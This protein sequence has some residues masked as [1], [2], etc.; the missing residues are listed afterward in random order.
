[1][2]IF[3]SIYSPDKDLCPK[4]S[5]FA[6]NVFSILKLGERSTFYPDLLTILNRQQS[7]KITLS[8]RADIFLASDLVESSCINSNRTS[9]EQI[10]PAQEIKEYKS[11]LLLF[12][13]TVPE[14]I[15][16]SFDFIMPV[17]LTDQ[18]DLEGLD[19]L[20]GKLDKPFF[21]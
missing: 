2:S 9:L 19:K 10:P 15:P 12:S 6:E 4:I 13:D 1:M 3:V 20:R 8:S 16:P 17:A 11:L 21:S 14:N 5:E 7:S 18:A